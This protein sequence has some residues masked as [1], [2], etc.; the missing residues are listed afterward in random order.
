MEYTSPPDFVPFD[1]SRPSLESSCGSFDSVDINYFLGSI[2]GID[3]ASTFTLAH[4]SSPVLDW[5]PVLDWATND[6]GLFPSP[7]ETPFAF[8]GCGNG[9][10]VLW[11]KPPVIEHNRDA[12]HNPV[13]PFSHTTLSSSNVQSYR[14]SIDITSH[15]ISSP[16]SLSMSSMSSS[17]SSSY[18]WDST[19]LPSRKRQGKSSKRPTARSSLPAISGQ[20]L[21][22]LRNALFCNPK[23]TADQSL[24][25]AKC[26]HVDE[27]VLQLWQKALLADEISTLKG[28]KPRKSLKVSRV[29]SW[30]QKIISQ[31][32]QKVKSPSS[33]QIEFLAAGLRI[34]V[35]QLWQS[36]RETVN[37]GTLV[38][39][40]SRGRIKTEL[41]PATDLTKELSPPSDDEVQPVDSRMETS[42]KFDDSPIVFLPSKPST[43]GV[44]S[45]DSG[46]WVPLIESETK[47]VNP[48]DVG[49]AKLQD[50]QHLQSIVDK[51]ESVPDCKPSVEQTP[52]EVETLAMSNVSDTD[53]ESVDEEKVIDLSPEEELA[54]LLGPEYGGL[55]ESILSRFAAAS[56]W[57]QWQFASGFRQNAGGVGNTPSSNSSHTPGNTSSPNT[58]ASGSSGGKRKSSGGGGEGP[59]DHLEPNDGD[60]NMHPPPPKKVKT[61]QLRY[62]CPIFRKSLGTES[63]VRSC[64]LNGLEFRNLW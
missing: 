10:S 8:T 59:G 51:I 50:C 7:A 38:E 63:T 2:E 11:G 21:D 42:T 16:P 45:S 29:A 49:D 52:G 57:D 3:L 40:K 18:S 36:F 64:A 27:S 47:P 41:P 26:L 48:V 35:E 15:D 14:N 55:A 25:L 62:D 24:F 1:S 6:L 44:N 30:K 58:S 31:G 22:V 53:M 20:K 61:T 13:T 56:V 43:V 46:P 9:Q 4:T 5:E 60:G 17:E 34:K 19:Q 12:Q 33:Y 28:P 23:P 54:A 37:S 32:L 39:A